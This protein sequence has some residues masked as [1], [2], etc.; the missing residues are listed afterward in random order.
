[1]TVIRILIGILAINDFVYYVI[2]EVKTSSLLII[3]RY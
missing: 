3:R 2:E 1:M